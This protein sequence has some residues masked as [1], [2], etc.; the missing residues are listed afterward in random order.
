MNQECDP[1]NVPDN[2]Q[3][4]MV[5]QLTGEVQWRYVPGRVLNAKKGDLILDPGGPG[6]VGQLLRQITPPQFYSHCAIMTKNHIELRHS[7]GSDDW[8]EDHPAGSSLGHKGTDGFEPAALKY[9][10]PGTVTQTIDNAYYGEWMVSPDKG[11]YRIADFSFKADASDST[12]LIYPVVVKPES[13]R[14]NHGDLPD[15]TRDRRC[16]TPYR[17]PLP[18]LLLQQAGDCAGAGRRRGT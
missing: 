13:P 17:Q 7:T 9:L 4:G 1:D 12:T 8:L 16:R 3:D 15:V 14:R 18:L 11:P 2:L 6:L 5:C 10:W